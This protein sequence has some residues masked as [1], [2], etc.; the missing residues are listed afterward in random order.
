MSNRVL[1][2]EDDS[3]IARFVGMALEE[4]P[5]ELVVCTSVAKALDALRA[6]PVR[7]VITDLMLPG[8]SGLS[9]LQALQDQPALR[10]EALL[11][12]FSAG[13]TTDVR[14][15][16]N[17]LQVWRILSK[18]A[19]VAALEACVRDAL[20]LTA[21]A[22]RLTGGTEVD[23]TAEERLAITTHFA[24]DT[25]LFRAYRD[26]C[27]TQFSADCLAGDQAMAVQD[28][29]ALRRLAHSLATVLLTLGYQEASVVARALEATAQTSDLQGMAE[30]WQ[31]L[32]LWLVARRDS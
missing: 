10:R 31:R 3:S 23:L 27:F 30:D 2:V 18:P 21:E 7:L 16:L 19:S 14:Q 9:L 25:A 22:E 4:L 5:V 28:A 26:S 13:V 6:Q 15:Q 17:A 8:E 29:P 20:Q 24:G 32:K 11:V 12:V 1:L